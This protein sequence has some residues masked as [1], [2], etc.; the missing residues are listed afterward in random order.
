MTSL[1]DMRQGGRP[2]AGLHR[3]AAQLPRPTR[4][5]TAPCCARA[6]CLCL[7]G[8][9]TNAGLKRMASAQ[10]GASY[11]D[12]LYA[13]RR[14]V[15]SDQLR[16]ADRGGDQRHAARPR[17]PD[18]GRGHERLRLRQQA[19]RR[20]GPEPDDPVA[21]PLRR[22]RGD[23]LLARRA[24]V[25][26]H[27]LAAEIALL[28]RGRQHDRGRAAPLHRAGGGPAV[29]GQPRAERR[30]LRVHE[31][32][33]ASS[34]C[35]GSRRSTRNASTGPRPASP[36]PTPTCSPCCPGRSTGT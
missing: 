14:Y 22:A 13:R 35:R 18:L 3:P 30:R 20:L 36:T 8:L 33:R 32:A 17:P 19:L 31:T 10:H 6:C 16:E 15:T 25:A 23:D 1:L 28:V 29:R 4:R 12:L 27:P 24:Q 21:R 11:K 7:N 9:G 2:A 34:S 5:S 26:V